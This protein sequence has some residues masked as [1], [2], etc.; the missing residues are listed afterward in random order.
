MIAAAR[1]PWRRRLTP[2]RPARMPPAL[3]ATLI[4]VF[5]EGVDAVRVIE[6]SWFACLHVRALATTRRRRI[7]L[8][9]GAAPFFADPT[10]VLHEFFHV[11]GQWEPRRLSVWKYV[12]ELFRRGYWDNRFEIEAREFAEDHRHRYCALLARHQAATERQHA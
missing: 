6:H 1:T 9:D 7:Y 2:G 12:V 8:R 10:I 5:G 3:R 11:L 4:E